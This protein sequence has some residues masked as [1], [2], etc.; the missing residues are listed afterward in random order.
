LKPG[1]GR[2][3][4]S[5]GAGN[6]RFPARMT[7]TARRVAQTSTNCAKNEHFAAH[8]TSVKGTLTFLQSFVGARQ[9]TVVATTQHAA[10][11]NQTYL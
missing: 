1:F 5:F 8:L 10:A 7:S 9:H 11:V 6:L 2:V 3:F 4:F